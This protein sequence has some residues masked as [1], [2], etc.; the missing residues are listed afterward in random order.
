MEKRYG[1]FYFKRKDLGIG[2]DD[3]TRYIVNPDVCLYKIPYRPDSEGEEFYVHKTKN[4][5]RQFYKLHFGE[6]WVILKV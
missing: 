4:H 6:N 3:G 5:G 1:A 2:L